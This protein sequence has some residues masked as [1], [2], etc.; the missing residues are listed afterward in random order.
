MT[1]TKK[2]ATII[3]S[4]VCIFASAS[5]TTKADEI[6]TAAQ[7]EFPVEKVVFTWGYPFAQTSNIKNQS[8]YGEAYIDVYN[9]ATGVRLDSAKK[10]LALGYYKHARAELPAKYAEDG[11]R[12]KSDMLIRRDSSPTSSID[13]SYH[14][15]H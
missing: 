3:L 7:M 8:R 12:Y 14:I 2:I 5:L 10:Q 13:R 11:Y 15:D 4:A 9:G 6:S 1:R